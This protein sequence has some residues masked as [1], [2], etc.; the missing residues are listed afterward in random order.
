[1]A[2]INTLLAI[3]NMKNIVDFVKMVELN[4][5]GIVF[6]KALGYDKE[7]SVSFKQDSLT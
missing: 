1:V 2:N 4:K 6:Q 5:K 3:Y 7:T